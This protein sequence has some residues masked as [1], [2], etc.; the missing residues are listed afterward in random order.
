MVGTLSA[1]LLT[2]GALALIESI[3]VLAF[4][5]WSIRKVKK[6]VKNQKRVRKAGFIELV[7]ALVLIAIA[8][9]I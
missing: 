1:V 4:P 5:N 6:V 7:V 8:F 3:V 2:V 9:L